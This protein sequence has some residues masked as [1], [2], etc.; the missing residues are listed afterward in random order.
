MLTFRIILGSIL[1]LFGG[2]FFVLATV[3][4]GF[5][6]S[7]GASPLSSLFVILPLAGMLLLLA[8]L[9]FPA[10]KLL[11]HVGAV[12]AV[13]LVGFCIW[14]MVYEGGGVLWLALVVFGSWFVFY[15]QAA[16]GAGGQVK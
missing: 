11:L 12:A 1:L 3:S 15:W 10:H 6:K 14:Q 5:R 13:G 7:F 2:S 9:I 16:H 4:R 8:A